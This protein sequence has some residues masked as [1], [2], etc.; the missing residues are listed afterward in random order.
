MEGC[1]ASEDPGTPPAVGADRAQPTSPGAAAWCTVA[2]ALVA[3]ISSFGLPNRL[4]WDDLALIGD[5]PT[6]VTAD[7]FLSAFHS[8][9]FDRTGESTDRHYYRPLV[10]AS[11][12]L[13]VAL[14]GRD[15]FFFG[16]GN[17]A[18][19]ILA[20]GLLF[21]LLRRAGADPP[22]AAAGTLLFGLMPR[23]TESVYWISGRTDVLATVFVLGA[24]LSWDAGPRGARRRIGAA[25]LLWLG[26]LCKEVALA[27]VA[28]LLVAEWARMLRTTPGDAPDGSH[29]PDLRMLARRT[30]LLLVPVACYG[31]VRVAALQ[32][33]WQTTL[34][35]DA[36]ARLAL[37]AEALGRYVLLLLDPLH[38]ALRIGHVVAPRDPLLMLLGGASA[39]LGLVLAVRGLPRLAGRPE[40]VGVALAAAALAPT[41]HLVPIGSDT[42]AADRFLYLPFAGAVLA[43][44]PAVV[45][46]PRRA[47]LACAGAAIFAIGLFA[48]ACVDRAAQWSDDVLLWHHTLAHADPLDSVPHAW[49]GLALQER[50]EPAA[51][52][53]H[54]KQAIR[55]EM[56]KPPEYRKRTL[57]LDQL[58]NVSAA[59]SALGRDPEA[60]RAIQDAIGRRPG[61]APY[62]EQRARVLARLLRFD[63]ARAA[64]ETARRLGGDAPRLARWSAEIEAVERAWSALPA[65]TPEE[66]TS[67][68][69]ERALLLERVGADPAASQVWQLVLARPD[70]EPDWIAGAAVFH[71]VRAHRVRASALIERLSSVSARHR[72][73]ARLL[74]EALQASRRDPVPDRILDAAADLEARS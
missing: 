54:F 13:G 36:G 51:A 39:A 58:A 7:A 28:A 69:V 21:A 14:W 35:L 17:L 18:F 5:L 63:D 16:V 59:L 66:P 31:V 42:I 25:V 62:H 60:L 71:T 15:A 74:R 6:P 10:Q 56:A 65:P 32:G 33:A 50:E 57:V 19:H 67:V 22:A 61:H 49:M 26:L 44:T 70:V 41:L 40:L 43:A 48:M 30:A 47:R 34:S 73:D 45:R 8:D 24:L 20:C 72:D 1:T 4:V 37:A 29:G 9:F 3:A 55:I 23:L 46:W 27:G 53:A 64:I 12:L 52:L 2:L 38:P 11:Y 68:L